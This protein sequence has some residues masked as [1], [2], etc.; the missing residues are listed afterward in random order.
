M[1]STASRATDLRADTTECRCAGVARGSESADGRNRIFRPTR[2]RGSAPRR[3]RRT[4]RS[5]IS[6]FR[7]RATTASSTNTIS[8]EPLFD[9]SGAFTG[10][11]GVGTD[12]TGRKRA[13]KAAV[14]ASTGTDPVQQRPGSM[15]DRSDGRSIEVN[16]RFCDLLGY[17][18]EEMLG[19]EPANSPTRK[20]E[21]FRGKRAS[22][23][24]PADAYLR[25]RAAPPRR[26]QRPDRVP[27]RQ[28]VQ[29][30]RFRDGS[31]RVRDRTHR[32][33]APA[34]RTAPPER[35]SR[36]SRGR[37]HARTG[38]GQQ[39]TEIVLLLRVP[40]PARAA[41]RDRRILQD[42][43]G[44]ARRATRRAGQ[45]PPRARVRRRR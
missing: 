4:S 5:A 36:A 7:A 32:A 14:T 30:G 37:A 41:A 8:G 15:D 34:G 1:P 35:G 39:R 44:G 24:Q 43:A 40:R 22:Y 6:S 17:L 26:A 12:M 20:T 13:E 33:Q 18:P 3:A 10:Y 9:A 23:S 19:K 45:A 29:R 11:R 31:A 21:G 27:R 2:R 25:S 28:P 42:P 38:S 16:H